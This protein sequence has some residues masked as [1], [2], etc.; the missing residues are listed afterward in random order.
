MTWS[1]DD[2]IRIGGKL[3]N[4][5]SRSDENK[6]A[7]FTAAGET[8]QPEG[9]VYK[10]FY[11]ASICNGGTPALPRT[12]VWRDGRIDHLPMYAESST[13]NLQFQNLCTVYSVQLK[14]PSTQTVGSIVVT[15]TA[16]G[17]YLS[18]PFTVAWN[19][20]D[21]VMTMTGGEGSSRSVTLDLGAGGVA[22]SPV[23]EKEFLIALPP[24]TYEKGRLTLRI[25]DRD[26]KDIVEPY[27]S[28]RDF[29]PLRSHCYVIGKELFDWKYTI[30]WTRPSSGL[31]FEP[32]LN[33]G[34][35][36]TGLKS[37][38]TKGTETEPAPFKMQYAA[39]DS[40]PWEDGLPGWMDAESASGF[41][42]RV[43]GET[44][45]LYLRA[46]TDPVPD[47]NVHTQALR[48]RT[49]VTD[50]DLSTY[51]VAAGSTV[52]R[53][54]ANCYV[55]QAPGTYIFPLVYGNALRNGSIYE[56]AFRRQRTP[57]SNAAYYLE[58]WLDHNDERNGLVCE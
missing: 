41:A 17:Q 57:V 2:S 43:G 58:Y 33:T 32:T 38:R 27:S 16:E 9:G 8:A 10:A 44:L 21:P 23:S 46:L 34:R 35:S 24:Q 50:F 14:G 56:P 28:V 52:A 39:S 30:S 18:G 49:P 1:A 25:L 7:T 29:T 40:G 5:S 22:L 3:Y 47:P 31:Y 48:S 54:T 26:G 13:S 53:T 4:V 12:Q 6:T 55:V 19:E 37:F 51:N 11:P 20:G 36:I 45:R 15:T 42:G